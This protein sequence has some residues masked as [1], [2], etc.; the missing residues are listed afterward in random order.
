MAVPSTLGPLSYIRVWHDNSGKG[1]FRSWFLSYIVV[2]D[3]Q[4]NERYEFIC[5]KWFAVEKGDG[6]LDRLLPVAGAW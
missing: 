4:T 5:N 6:N 3:I 1:K 2:R